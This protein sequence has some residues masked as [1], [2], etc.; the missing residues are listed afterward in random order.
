MLPSITV[1]HENILCNRQ[2]L[3]KNKTIQIE[4]SDTYL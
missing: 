2:M 3:N 1:A 4:L